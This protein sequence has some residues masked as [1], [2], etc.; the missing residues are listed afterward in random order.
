MRRAPTTPLE[1]SLTA[2]LR[3]PCRAR[4]ASCCLCVPV[5]R[6][7]HRGDSKPLFSPRPH[8]GPAPVSQQDGGRRRGTRPEGIARRKVR[9]DNRVR[10]VVCP[11]RSVREADRGQGARRVHWILHGLLGRDRSLRAP[12]PTARVP[13]TE[14]ACSAVFSASCAGEGGDLCG[15]QVRRQPRAHT[16][17]QHTRRHTRT[18]KTDART[19]KRSCGG[20]WPIAAPRAGHGSFDGGRRTRIQAAGCC[21]S[22]SLMGR[23]TGLALTYRSSQLPPQSWTSARLRCLGTG[24]S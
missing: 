15:Y 20:G 17:R 14:R 2:F 13:L 22:L 23:R 11:V 1:R 7:S 19:L 4:D 18:H 21:T 24:S 6:L 12:C 5:T 3:P 10:Y 16:R 8:F 9:Q